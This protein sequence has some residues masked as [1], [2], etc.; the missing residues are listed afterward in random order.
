ML[1]VFQALPTQRARV[2]IIENTILASLDEKR[3]Y[4]AEDKFFVRC[5]Q[6]AAKARRAWAH[7]LE[8]AL[9]QPRT[10]QKDGPE[11]MWAARVFSVLTTMAARLY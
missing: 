11:S 6:K 5:R 1:D 7:R 3:R 4:S 10:D 2:D 9:M 8:D